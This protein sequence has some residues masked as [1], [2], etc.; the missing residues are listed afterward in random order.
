LP[1]LVGNE[2]RGAAAV[3]LTAADEDRLRAAMRHLQWG[4]GWLRTDTAVAPDHSDAA[5]SP[6]LDVLGAVVEEAG[7]HAA[8]QRAVTDLAVRFGCDRVSLG[9]RRGATVHV[10]A[11]SH[12]AF[13]QRRGSEAALLAAAMEEAIDQRA[14]LRFPPSDDDQREPLARHAQEQVAGLSNATVLTIPLTRG[15]DVVG[16]LLLERLAPLERE[17][18]ARLDVIAALLGPILWEKWREDRWLITKARETLCGNV[19][20]LFGPDHVGRKLAALACV[21]LVVLGATW[22]VDYTV[23]AQARLEGAV[24]RSI[25]APMDGFLRDAPV[26]AGDHVHAG[27]VLA[28]LDDRD[29]TLE[30]LHWSAVRAQRVHELDRAVGEERRADANILHAELDQADAQLALADA[31]L[32][33]TRF[34]APFDALVVSGDHSQNIGT[35]VRRGDVLFELAP[36][37]NWRVV[38]SVAE[39][40]VG[41][42][43]PGQ[44]GSLTAA[45]M[46]WQRLPF[47][48]S[49]VTPIARVEDGETV[50][51]VEAT[52]E[53]SS[54]R[55]WPGM[56]GVARIDAG[57]RLAAWVWTRRMLEKARLLVWQV[58]P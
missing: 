42:V 13:V 31:Q 8:A 35:A 28:Q 34:V 10:L 54:P 57:E 26:R 33:R 23:V 37:D 30:R 21:S 7:F 2:L 3:A 20:M 51:E 25:V 55:L 38:A 53:Q 52:L 58:M 14:I 48:V 17:A 50:F 39:D 27:E 41:D 15:D 22:H 19:R 4:A 12:C 45:A 5:Q 32:A 1:L 44:T 16:A 46:P 36:L 11:I 6:I 24:R 40:Q 18:I 56:Q 9:F 29:L 43:Q 47:T 49:R